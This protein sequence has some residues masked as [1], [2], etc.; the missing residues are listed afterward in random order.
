MKE[1]I[2]LLDLQGVLGMHLVDEVVLVSFKIED[3]YKN[4]KGDICMY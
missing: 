2:V 4:I 1:N 3:P